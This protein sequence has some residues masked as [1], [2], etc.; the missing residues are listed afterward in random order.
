MLAL[1]VPEPPGNEQKQAMV[2]RICS[3]P[4]NSMLSR[5][6]WDNSDILKAHKNRIAGRNREATVRRVVRRDPSQVCGCFALAHLGV[7]ELQDR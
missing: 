3:D 5:F 1:W 2:V 7:L 4:A 6:N